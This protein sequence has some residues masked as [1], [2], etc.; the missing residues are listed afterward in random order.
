MRV[1]GFLRGIFLGSVVAVGGLVVVS[2]LAGPGPGPQV[3]G[4]G[5]ANSTDAAP[6]APEAPVTDVTEATAPDAPKAPAPD[7]TEAAAPSAPDAPAPAATTTAPDADAGA[8]PLVDA[9][10]PS[11]PAAPGTV[12]PPSA[13]PAVADDAAPSSSGVAP[14]VLGQEADAPATALTLPAE[15]PVQPQT[16]APGSGQ[17]MEGAGG[18]MA[19]AP[20]VVANAATDPSAAL[21]PMAP[22]IP[23]AEIAPK[24][25]DLPPASVPAPQDDLLQPVTPKPETTQPD[26]A[27]TPEIAALPEALQPDQNATLAPTPSLGDQAAGVVTD[28]LPRIGADP[29]ADAAALAAPPAP[30]QAD[31]PPME[32]YARAFSGAD[33]KPLFAILLDDTGDTGVNRQELAAMS[34][35]LSIVIDPLSEG[36]AERAAIW[37]A[38]GQE[39]IMTA[40]GIPS[41]ATASDLEQ[42][43]QALATALPEAVAVIDADGLTFQDNRPL[44]T[45]VVPI[46][47]GQGRGLV[48]FDRGLNAADQVARRENLGAATIFRRLDGDGE[49]SPVIRRYLDR[50]AFKAAQD[51]RVAVIG[52]LRPATIAAILE[53]AV[54]GKSATV[55]LAP[56]TALMAR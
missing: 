43:F 23:G 37:R 38:G 56:I 27:A 20:S 6:D 40:S 51:G 24:P 52:T 22:E 15:P 12:T 47:A 49:D 3:Q 14:P 11:S 33:G 13:P 53:W 18:A 36:A 44:A 31:L 16:S 5:I 48:T 39:V 32:R 34:L 50:A 30:D 17:V 4:S 21:P 42:T 45:E 46:L 10:A 35:P 54:E 19:T 29:A 2:Q 8:L 9:D 1:V 55:T 7:M 28:R 25:A 26:A 41:G